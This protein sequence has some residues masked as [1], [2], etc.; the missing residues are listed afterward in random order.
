M[1]NEKFSPLKRLISFKYAFKGISTLWEKEHN[2]RIHVFVA[3][4]TLLVGFFVDL[5]QIQWIAILVCI[6]LVMAMEAINS[7]IEALADFICP[8]ED[9]RIK[10]LK[11]M[12]AAAVLFVSIAAFIVGLIVF[13]PKFIEL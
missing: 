3:I 7:S 11:D 6:A 4:V 10:R 13:I 1:K 5:S 12:S 2:F 9:L 8:Q